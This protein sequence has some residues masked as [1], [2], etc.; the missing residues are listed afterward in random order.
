MELALKGIIVGLIIVLPGMSGGTVFLILGLYETMIK[1]LVKFNLKPYL[2]LVIGMTVG[3]F[4]AGLSLA[5]IFEQYRDPSAMFL[6]GCVLASLQP[7]L[8]GQATKNPRH[9]F[10]LAAGFII[11]FLMAGE[12]IEIADSVGDASLPYLMLSGALASATMI[13]P[14]LPGSGVMIIMGIYDDVLFYLSQ[15]QLLEL[16]VFGAGGIIGILGLAKGLE[17]MYTHYRKAIAYGFSGLIIGSSRALLPEVWTPFVV[18]VGIL[19]FSI[20]YYYG[21]GK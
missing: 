21:R 20:V 1:D 3:I 15:F 19:G 8:R 14:G 17:S 6:L 9:Y 5:F 11:G 4:I 2:P 16:A 13:V 7:I 10:I 12:P 18:I